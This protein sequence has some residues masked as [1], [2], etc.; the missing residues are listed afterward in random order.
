MEQMMQD[1]E[2]QTTVQKEASKIF[3][4]GNAPVTLKFHD[5]VYKV[6]AKKKEQRVILSGVTG[7]VQPG[8]I[9]AI[10]GPSG[11]GKTTLLTALGGRLGGNLSGTIAYNGKLFSNSMKKSIG[12]VTQEDILY[13]HLTVTETLVFTSLLRLPNSFT[14]QEKI[15]HAKSVI[16]LLG[17]TKC[18]DSIIGKPMLRGVSGGER[19]RVSIGQEMLINP[20]LLFLDEPTSGLDSTTAQ[21]IV[22][23]LWELAIGGR[24]VVMTI[25]QPSSRIYHMFHTVLLLSEG[26]PLYYGKGSEA[27]EYFSGVGY[28]PAIAMN[29]SDFLLDLANGVYTDQSNEDHALNKQKLVSAYKNYFDA[30]WKPIILDENPDND[31]SQSRFEDSGFGKWSTTWWQQF[32][33]L[34][35]RDLK[36]RKH[37]PFSALRI[38]KVIVIA[39]I[40]GLLWYRSN[41]SQLGDQIGL[42]FFINSFWAVLPFYKAIFTFPQ[43]ATMLEK[44]R[45]SGMYRLSSY[46]ISPIIVDLPVELILPTIYLIIIYFMTGLKLNVINFLYTLLTLLLDVLVSQGLGLAIGAIIMDTKSAITLGSIILLS[47]VLAVGFYVRHVPNFIAWIKYISINYYIYKLFLGSQY[48]TNETYPCSNGKCLISEFPLIK[49]M[50]ELHLQGQLMALL[51]LFIMLIGYRVMAYFALTRIGVTKKIPT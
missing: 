45:S 29:P 2:A 43:E 33:V 47:F 37:E 48:D 38:C 10:L 8:E 50:G 41:I 24:T 13:A 15:E 19:K 36:E 5:V 34:L 23:N 26:I 6:K 1:I 28:E 32:I 11:S 27:M 46:F 22:S 9:L 7:M 51:A 31:E 44:E 49:Q 42:L 20:S 4:K 25:H 14:K 18:K 16:S 17:L 40:T 39:L 3:H 21:K 35:K 12:F 30:K